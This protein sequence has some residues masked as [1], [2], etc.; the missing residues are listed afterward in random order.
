MCYND[1]DWGNENLDFHLHSGACVV[2]GLRRGFAGRNLP[3]GGFILGAADRL[4]FRQPRVRASFRTR[5]RRAE[6]HCRGE[7]ENPCRVHG[8]DRLLAVPGGSEVARARR[9][10]RIRGARAGRGVRLAVGQNRSERRRLR[11]PLDRRHPFDAVASGQDR[12]RRPSAL[13]RRGDVLEARRNFVRP[14]HG[15]RREARADLRMLEGMGP[16]VRYA[17]LHDGD[18]SGQQG[19]LPLRGQDALARQVVLER[20]EQSRERRAWSRWHVLVPLRRRA[21]RRNRHACGGG[22][23]DGQVRAR[24]VADASARLACACR[25]GAKGTIQVLRRVPALSVFQE[26]WSV[27]LRRIRILARHI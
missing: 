13:A 8:E 22:R 27:Q 6:G 15:R 1:E 14:L 11:F 4:A 9:A 17:G 24:D 7:G 5:G 20:A 25:K 26:V 21:V 3:R 2:R 12:V 23:G 16:F 19:I 10:V 18:D